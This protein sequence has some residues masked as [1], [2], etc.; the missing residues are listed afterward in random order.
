M[1][2]KEIILKSRPAELPSPPRSLDHADHVVSVGLAGHTKLAADH[3]L[4]REMVGNLVNVIR[5]IIRR[6][7]LIFR[8]SVGRDERAVLN[9]SRIY[10]TMAQLALNLIGVEKKWIGFSEEEVEISLTKILNAIK[11]WE[12]VEG[13]EFGGHPISKATVEKILSELKKVMSGYYRPPG[14]MC[15][16]MAKEIEEKINWDS[17]VSS[18]I[19]VAKEVIQD[20]IYYKMSM[21]GYCKFGN[22]YALGLRWVRHLGYVQVSTNPTLAA[23]AYDDDPTLWEGF[24]DESFCQDLK[25]AVMKHPE[26]VKDP[27]K[28]ADELAMK[29]TE[30]SIFP[31]LAV[32]R[33]IAVASDFYHGLVSLQLSPYVTKSVEYSVKQAMQI[34]MDA[35]EFL[36]RYDEYLLWGYSNQVWRGRPNIVFKVTGDSPAAIDITSILES[37]GIGTN[38]TVTFTV[39]QETTLILAKIEG[40]AKAVKLGILPTMCY[41]TTMGGRLDDHIREVQAEALLKRAVERAGEGCVKELAEK[42]GAWDKIKDLPIEEKIR[43]VCSRRYLRPMNKRPFAEVLAKAGVVEGGVDE[44][45]KYLDRLEHDIGHA[46][47]EVTHRVY[48]IFFSPENKPKWI[49]YIM[50]KY[51]LSEDEAREV[52]DRIDVLPAS[53]RKPID[54]L[55]T[56]AW[57]NMTN[58]EFPNHQTN[59]LMFSRRPDFR[60]EDYRDSVLKE[61]DQSIIHRLTEEYQDI[62]EDCR[63]AL[64]LNPELIERLKEAGVEVDFGVRGHLP[65]DWPQF[66]SVVKTM[67][68]FT[69]SYTRFRER[70]V[71]FVK[72]LSS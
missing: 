71:E 34:Y 72:K 63:A 45:Q 48:K 30:L 38:N 25:T 56:L 70:V 1:E 43:I 29:A 64:E 35:E 53:K 21:D 62:R 36:K 42:L 69:R 61:I 3:L 68:E 41:E 15:S 14:S 66:G 11:E 7:N 20:N 50:S 17:P 31:N 33:P 19:S 51:G 22:D 8:A 6:F 57:M 4:N 23:V 18:F 39:A 55:L 10:E 44:A 46:G 47:I 54:T 65:K 58:T 52:L 32:F 13:D 59:I 28:Y 67:D 5:D 2:F 49:K 40:R 24:M 16:K 60:M 27:E 37:M 26:W 9:R 12:K